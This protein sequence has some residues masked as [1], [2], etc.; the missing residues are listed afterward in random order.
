MGNKNAG[1]PAGGQGRKDD[2]TPDDT[3]PAAPPAT[4]DP[5][6]RSVLMDIVRINGTLERSV[7]AAAA[8][9]SS[10]DLANSAVVR[11]SSALTQMKEAMAAQGET[12]AQLREEL[13]RK[14]TPKVEAT[15]TDDDIPDF[16]PDWYSVETEQQAQLI[17]SELIEWVGRVY[18]RGPTNA[19]LPHCWMWHPTVVDELMSLR[20]A[21][22][23]AHHG[24]HANGF[25]ASDWRDRYRKS[26]IERI[27]G[28]TKQCNLSKHDNQGDTPWKPVRVPGIDDVH[29]ADQVVAIARWWATGRDSAPPVPTA[30]LKAIERSSRVR[31]AD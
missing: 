15:D 3:A 12:I 6:L 11:V 24:E 23:D 5:I 8:A 31:T 28:A 17:L 22:L 18:L 7:A 4:G 25:K 27:N 29:P 20:W 13:K 1:R 9:Q 26:A 14:K 30:N 10:A 16:V 21:Y 19:T 2:P